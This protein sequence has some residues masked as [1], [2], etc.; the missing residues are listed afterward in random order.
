MS[1][2]LSICVTISWPVTDVEERRYE[3]SIY[4]MILPLY[5]YF[6]LL[7]LYCGNIKLDFPEPR[8]PY[9]PIV[10]LLLGKFPWVCA[11]FSEAIYIVSRNSKWTKCKVTQFLKS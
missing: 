7:P 10:L 8:I 4:S 1:A 6:I 2:K 5:F 11:V 3:Y 9:W